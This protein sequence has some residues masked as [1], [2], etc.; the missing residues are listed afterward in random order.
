VP[1]SNLSGRENLHRIKCSRAIDFSIIQQLM[2]KGRPGFLLRVLLTKE[3]L[4]AVTSFLF[5]HTSTIGLRYQQVER[6]ELDRSLKQ[7]KTA[8]GSIQ[9]K[10]S[11]LPNNEIRRKP[12]YEDIQRLAKQHDKSPLQI[13]QAIDLNKPDTSQQEQNI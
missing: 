10:E 12:E 1:L 9:V 5:Q 2:K 6:V 11:I 7:L 4:S 3:K 13:R 8:F